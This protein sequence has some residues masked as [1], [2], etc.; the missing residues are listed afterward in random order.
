[1][2]VFGGGGQSKQKL[3]FDLIWKSQIFKLFELLYELLYFYVSQTNKLV[4]VLEI[5]QY[6]CI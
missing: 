5:M 4:H 3:S 6:D 1:M 2:I